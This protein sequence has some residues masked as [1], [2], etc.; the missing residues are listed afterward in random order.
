M[1]RRIK[2]RKTL[3]ITVL[4]SLIF[5]FAQLA[6][7]QV[8]IGSGQV[9]NKDAILDLKQETKTT[10]GLLL[11]RVSLEQTTISN[12]LSAHVEGMVVYNIASVGDVT[13]GYYYNNGSKWM[14]LFSAEDSFFYMPSTVLPT[15]ENDTASFDGTKFKVNLYDEYKKQFGLT[16]NIAVSDNTAKLPIYNSNELYYFVTYYD[17]TVFDDV[18]ISATG[19]LTYKLKAGFIY[20]EKTFMNIVLKVK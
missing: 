2:Y 8:T 4:T 10:K 12:P 16:G 11:P 13:P 14:K 20:T 9:P 3:K 18:K 6:Q 5:C 19:E 17:N 15:D 7:A 1:K